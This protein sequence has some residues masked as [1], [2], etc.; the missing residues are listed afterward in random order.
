MKLSHL[1]I[2]FLCY[3]SINTDLFFFDDLYVPSMSPVESPTTHPTLGPTM[4]P[5]EMPSFYPTRDTEGPTREP[6]VPPTQQPT[7]MPTL[8]CDTDP[9]RL[10][11]IRSSME[12][13]INALWLIHKINDPFYEELIELDLSCTDTTPPSE[14]PTEQP[15]I[16]PTEEPKELRIKPDRNSDIDP[17]VSLRCAMHCDCSHF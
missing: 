6:T 16:Q 5:S 1:A 14:Q 15:T 7:L 10:R 9:G 8:M 13:E 12:P 4:P 2:N 17:Y 3:F 11:E